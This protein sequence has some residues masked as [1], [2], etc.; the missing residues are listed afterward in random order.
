MSTEAKV[1]LVDLIY[2]FSQKA[3][4]HNLFVKGY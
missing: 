4:E 3:S 2:L 1:D